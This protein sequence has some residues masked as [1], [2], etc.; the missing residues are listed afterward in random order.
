M[1][2]APAEE[3]I[4]GGGGELERVGVMRR[5]EIPLLCNRGV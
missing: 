2:K 1:K 5:P 4:E 3:E